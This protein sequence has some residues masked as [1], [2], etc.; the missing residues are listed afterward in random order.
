MA[1]SPQVVRQQAP[2]TYSAASQGTT[3]QKQ[4]T[5]ALAVR[6]KQQKDKDAAFQLGVAHTRG[7]LGLR[8]DLE[9]ARE[10]FKIALD[11]KEEHSEIEN[12]IRRAAEKFCFDNKSILGEDLTMEVI[13]GEKEFNKGHYESLHYVPS[14]FLFNLDMYNGNIPDELKRKIETEPGRKERSC[15]NTTKK[16]KECSEAGLMAATGFL[17]RLYCE[18]YGV[19]E[20]VNDGLSLL[21]QAANAGDAQSSMYLGEIYRKGLHGISRDLGEAH[22]WYK[23]ADNQ[24]IPE[25]QTKLKEIE[26]FKKA[27]KCVLL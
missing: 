18:A 6:A 10:Y 20:N 3:P 12:R 2:L 1:A 27:A 13:D 5:D 19:E 22:V 9:K 11:Y 26:K 25:A 24:G 21:K 16:I 8:F 7:Y 14:K 15:S 23:K 17:G 4:F